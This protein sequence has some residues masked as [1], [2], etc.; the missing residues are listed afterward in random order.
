M[1]FKGLVDELNMKKDLKASLPKIDS[2][3][4]SERKMVEEEIVKYIKK[5][6]K[7]SYQYI[8]Y[9]KTI[10]IEEELSNSLD[11]FTL[12]DKAIIYK[13][14]YIA[15]KKEV[16]LDNIALISLED[17][18]S[19][20]NLIELL[21]KE[22]NY[23]NKI[24]ILKRILSIIKYTKNKDYIK[25]FEKRFNYNLKNINISEL[26]KKVEPFKVT[27]QEKENMND[28][29]I[30]GVLGFAI[31]DALG[32]PV[33]F[34]SR[35]ERNMNP[36]TDML[37]YGSHKV[38]EG[39]WSDD[40]SMT[41]ATIDSIIENVGI[42]Y[43]DIMNRFILWENKAYYTATGLFF[44]IG[45]TTR[46]ALNKYQYQGIS[47]LQ[48]GSNSFRENGN[49]SLMRIL[50]ITLYSSM[51]KL[52]EDDKVKLINE[53]SSLT[54]AHEISRLGCKIYSDYIERL[55]N[56]NFDKKEAYEYIKTL[57]YE[58]YYS[59]ESINVYKRILKDDISKYR[60]NDIKSSGFVVDTLEASL[61]VTL[62]SNSYEEAVIKAVNL[63]EDTDT[64]GA[65]AGSI[66]GIIYKSKTFP[67]RWTR[68]LRKS[69]Y[70]INL[71]HE[72]SNTLE[73]IKKKENHEIK[74]SAKGK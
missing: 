29:I 72:F 68:K 55:I 53:V 59:E 31:G 33:E 2:L 35:F 51:L 43:D 46:N 64:V 45:N 12:I 42:N 69:D 41:I 66:N 7:T 36:T 17:K 15:T 65:I 22:L 60:I 58:K 50:P 38:P 27:Y 11:T 10:N 39:T 62:T 67:N 1:N 6:V 37:G 28:I 13:N 19:F 14:L 44:D 8:P 52:N 71:A 73:N 32:V 3:N 30:S 34:T 49:G 25:L 26:F 9:L 24:K 54:H 18:T 63:G 56:N 61:Y 48:C 74:D 70:L 23:E 21:N 20:E 4:I 16:Y 5:G 47:A 40:T 57:N